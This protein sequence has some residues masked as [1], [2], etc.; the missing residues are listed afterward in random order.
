MKKGK[1]DRQ[2][3]KYSFVHYFRELADQDMDGALDLEEFILALHLINQKR[4]GQLTVIPQK[5]PPEF[6]IKKNQTEVKRKKNKVSF[7]NSI[8]FASY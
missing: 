2:K 4:R 1:Q 5:I 6:F 3:M 8:S 7:T